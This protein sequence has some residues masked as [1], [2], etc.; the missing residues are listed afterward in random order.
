MDMVNWRKKKREMGRKKRGE[1]KKRNKLLKAMSL[2]EQYNFTYFNTNIV[3]SN[4]NI[5][6]KYP[7]KN[8]FMGQL[9]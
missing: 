6:S 2:Y 4:A 7:I 5:I 3:E 1:E 8:C 9:S